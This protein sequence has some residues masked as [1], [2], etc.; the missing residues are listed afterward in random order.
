MSCPKVALAGLAVI[1]VLCSGVTAGAAE[2]RVLASGS[3]KGALSQLAP[4]FQ[5]SS[6][7]M[8]TIEYGPAGATTG[9]I[10]KNDA[11]DVVIVSRSQIEK[12]QSSGK[13]LPENLVNI[14][15]IALGVAIRKGAPK[16]D[17]SSVEAFK[18][19]LLSARS[20][21]YRDPATGSTSGTYAANLLERLG[22]A[23]DLK[24]KLRLD[25]TEGDVPENVFLAVARGEIE[26]QIGQI[27]EIVIAPGVELAGPLPG[28]IQNTTVMAAGVV[29]TSKEPEAARAFIRFISSPAARSVLKATGFQ[30]V[31]E[32]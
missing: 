28:E 1:V 10:Q 21:G 4:D 2:I 11:A 17:V 32:N 29:A 24:P 9:R 26:M 8:A 13:V 27:T 19:S 12:L 20:I 18:R 30:M 3:L 22:L 16:P 31:N 15:G 7:N 5:K 23:E 6:G 25:R 14:A